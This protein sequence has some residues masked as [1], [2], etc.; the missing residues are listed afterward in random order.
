MSDFRFEFG[1]FNSKLIHFL[2]LTKQEVANDHFLLNFSKKKTIFRNCL[3]IAF[4]IELILSSGNR[5][6]MTWL[7]WQKWVIIFCC[8]QFSTEKNLLTYWCQS[9]PF[10]VSFLS[11]VAPNFSI[12]RTISASKK[13]NFIT[14]KVHFATKKVGFNPEKVD[15]E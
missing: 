8:Q 1:D 10:C 5:K 6:K 12:F 9:L 15:F 2:D 14:E 13:L 4:F 7:W 11:Q 3:K